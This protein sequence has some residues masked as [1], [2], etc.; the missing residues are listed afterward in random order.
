VTTSPA[1]LEL[2]GRTCV[3]SGANTGIGRVT[4]RAL[5]A[6][7]A[8]VVLACRSRDKAAPVLAEIAAD[9]LG[10]AELVPLDLMSLAAVRASA[11]AVRALGRPIDYLVNNPGGGGQRG[12]T[13]D[14]FELHFG[15]NH[16]GPYLWTRL[17][18]PSLAP[19]ARVVFV[20][21]NRHTLAHGIDWDAV[22]APTRTIV[23]MQEYGTS[24]LGNLLFQRELTRR[25]AP[26]RATTVALNP[27]KVGTDI[28]RRAPRLAQWVAR[29]F[30]LT[31][32]QGA[33]FVID[34]TAREDLVAHTGR[35]YDQGRE[36][37][38]SRWAQDDELAAELWRRSADWVSLPA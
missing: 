13:A 14:G 11:D 8:H 20:A 28:M 29:R 2:H 26:S 18:L 12:V 19:G 35:Y 16:L 31:A 15:V 38:P 21:S 36:R 25:L 10:T 5:A 24:K 30:L 32:E 17:L 1:L 6:R 7:G 9:G 4:A 3:V 23:G 37:Q 22:R 27:G 33:R 34:A